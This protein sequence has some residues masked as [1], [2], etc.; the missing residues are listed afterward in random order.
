MA[1]NAGTQWEVRTTGS[2]TNGGGFNI[3]STGTDFSQQDAAQVA[4]TD[5]VIGATTTQLTSVAHPFVAADVGNVINIVSGTGFTVQRVQ[6]ISVSGVTATCDKACGTA[7]SIGG[8]GNLGGGLATPTVAFPLIVAQNTVWIKAG[9]YN[10]SALLTVPAVA[11]SA[12]YIFGY[13]TTHGDDG[14]PPVLNMTANST[15]LMSVGSSGSLFVMHNIS[16]TSTA[17][18]KADCI[19][20]GNTGNILAL[21]RLSIVGFVIGLAGQGAIA[22]TTP[23]SMVLTDCAITGCSS[24]AI[25]FG[26]TLVLN[27]CYLNG[28]TGIQIVSSTFGASL[29][30]TNSF[31][32][33]GG[34]AGVQLQGPATLMRIQNCTIAFNVVDGLQTS[35]ASQNAFILAQSSIIYGNGGW[36]ISM[37]TSM[38][39][40]SN[41]YT[42]QNAYGANTLGNRN[43]VN[44]GI[45][46]VTLTANPFI[47]SPNFALNA[48]A[49]GGASCKGLGYPGLFPGGT[50]TGVMDI[51]AAQSGAGAVAPVSNFGYVG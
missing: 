7:A 21:S 49:G 32:T 26:G 15:Q 33:N 20:N 39:F 34:S 44:P 2:D 6:V 17:T 41:S 25:S 5:L 23:I 37:G 19:H 22:G 24:N 18:T 1:F 3:T 46:D 42:A 51:G 38:I 31:I 35:T 50:T 45:G 16:F 28:N 29:I 43:H 47:G 12:V 11:S 9:T 4:F 40:A 30:A 48:V 36:G 8:S 14:T 10:L 27:N 13:A